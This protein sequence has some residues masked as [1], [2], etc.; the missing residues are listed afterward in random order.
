MSEYT[1]FDNKRKR[2]NT[3]SSSSNTSVLSLKRIKQF[4]SMSGSH[5][6]ESITDPN[7]LFVPD[8][9]SP[10]LSQQPAVTMTA[11]EG[12]EDLIE[13]VLDRKLRITKTEIVQEI[14][15]AILDD[16]T[17]V[18]GRVFDLEIENGA[19]KDRLAKLEK[20]HMTEQENSKSAKVYAV[21]NDQYARRCNMVVFGLAEIR[22]EDPITL[23]AN[24]LKSKLRIQ[25]ND[26]DLEICHRLGTRT[27]NK[28]RPM[29][30]KFRYRDQK[31]DTMKARKAL[32]GT[33]IVLSEDMCS[34]MQALQRELQNHPGVSSTWTWNGKLFAKNLN[35]VISTI[36]YGKEW[37]SKFP[38][39][40]ADDDPDASRVKG[41]PPPAGDLASQQPRVISTQ[42]LPPQNQHDIPLNDQLERAGAG[43][44]VT[45]LMY[46]TN[47]PPPIWPTPSGFPPYPMAITQ[48]SPVIP[49]PPGTPTAAE[50]AGDGSAAAPSSQIP[51]FL[52]TPNKVIGEA[53]LATTT[54]APNQMG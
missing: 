13:G 35:G 32:K 1:E 44:G 46:P 20:A 7:G 22:N 25:V 10:E 14:K 29:I 12:L 11:H 42:D 33:G 45:Q 52:A 51:Q 18:K 54:P 47:L 16:I 15:T 38:T 19:L 43:P 50:R 6:E 8:P 23:V 3:S 34:E 17:E 26:R 53:P 4:L 40:S 41:P 5:S 2:D 28:T 37:Q 9:L 27:L 48:M 39:R 36:R 31:Y 49:R 24:L 30:V 21:E